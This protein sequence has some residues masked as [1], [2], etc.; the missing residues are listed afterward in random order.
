VLISAFNYLVLWLLASVIALWVLQISVP[1]G[2][3][4]AVVGGV[5]LGWHGRRHRHQYGNGSAH[6]R[7]PEPRSIGC[8][9]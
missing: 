7:G 1:L 4:A 3:V 9:P 8:R 6:L 5:M 2:A